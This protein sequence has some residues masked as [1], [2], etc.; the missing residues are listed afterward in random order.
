MKGD[1]KSFPLTDTGF[2][3]RDGRFS[4]DGR[5]IAYSSDVSGKHEIYVRSFPGPSREWQISS[6]GGKSPRWS[7][8]GTNIC[9]LTLDW[10]LTEIPLKTGAEVHVGTPRSLFSLSRDSEYE[11]YSRDKFLVNEQQGTF[12]PPNGSA[13]LGCCARPHEVVG[14]PRRTRLICSPLCSPN[15][16]LQG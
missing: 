7:D 15:E 16:S 8:D 1:L 13:E 5:W 11:V 6:G 10:K 9:Y 4:P 14:E 2:D 3:E 12:R